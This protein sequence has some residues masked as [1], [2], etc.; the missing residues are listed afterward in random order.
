[1][2]TRSHG[3][4][5][6]LFAALLA[7]ALIG[8]AAAGQF[9]LDLDSSDTEWTLGGEAKLEVSVDPALVGGYGVLSRG[10]L[11]DVVEVGTFQFTS[12]S[13]T[14]T[15]TIPDNEEYAGKLCRFRYIAYTAG[16]E[17]VGASPVAKKPI[18]PL[19]IE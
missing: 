11:G 3:L 8:T 2:R 1:M 9:F 10:I 18:A 16:G 13:F 6:G 12:P 4:A 7:L 17:A 19:E 5:G 15:T 14:I